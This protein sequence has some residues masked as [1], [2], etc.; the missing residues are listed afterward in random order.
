[1]AEPELWELGVRELEA[2][3]SLPIK[4]AAMISPSLV[5]A[6][7]LQLEQD[8]PPSRHVNILGWSDEKAANKAK[9]QQLAEQARAVIRPG[10][11]L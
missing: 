5:L 3:G 4:A 1:L 10:S 2:N 8:P 7:D 6:E 11:G 9:A